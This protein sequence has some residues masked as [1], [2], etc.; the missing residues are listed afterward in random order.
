MMMQVEKFNTYR[1]ISLVDKKVMQ[2]ATSTWVF[3]WTIS[4][5]ECPRKVEHATPFTSYPPFLT[6]VVALE[7]QLPQLRRPHPP[8]NHRQH[9]KQ[10]AWKN[11]FQAR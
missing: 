5:D 8:Q 3:T 7:E 10:K 11:Y 9:S 2:K 6:V 1:P 4:Y